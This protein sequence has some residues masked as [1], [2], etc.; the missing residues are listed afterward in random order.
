MSDF[1][2]FIDYP[3]GREEC[4][5]KLKEDISY[6]E[7]QTDESRGI[8]LAEIL[9]AYAVYY[10][11]A[12]HKPSALSDAVTQLEYMDRSA[13]KMLKSI[14]SMNDPVLTDYDAWMHRYGEYGSLKAALENHLEAVYWTERQLEK[15]LNL[16]KRRRHSK[17]LKIPLKSSLRNIT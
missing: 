2:G 1:S 10:T 3:N 12:T 16:N 4:V 8:I 11:S 6:L 7:N 17:A 9:S 15:S 5:K 14:K 13:R